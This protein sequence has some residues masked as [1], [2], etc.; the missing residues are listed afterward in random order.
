[1]KA[2]GV[3]AVVLGLAAWSRAAEPIDERMTVAEYGGKAPEASASADRAE[4]G[5]LR[6]IGVTLVLAGI[7]GALFLF[8]RR[9]RGGKRVVRGRNVTVLETAYL[10]PK[11]TLALVRI[12]NRILLIGMGQDVQ[13]LAQFDRPE[14]VLAFDGAFSD[15]LKEAL[16][17]P[18]EAPAPAAPPAREPIAQLRKAVDRWRHRLRGEVRA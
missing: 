12:R 4:P 16:D 5:M 14:E 9:L 11:H 6:P 1:M 15:E 3:A 10:S 8:C 17:A 18:A 7:G 13:T 2:N